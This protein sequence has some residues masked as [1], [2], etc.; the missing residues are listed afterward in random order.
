MCSQLAH[1]FVPDG[2]ELGQANAQ[3]LE[4]HKAIPIQVPQPEQR[5]ELGGVDIGRT[6]R[7]PVT[8]LLWLLVLLLL[9]LLLLRA[10][11][12]CGWRCCCCCCCA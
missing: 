7:A 1:L 5:L 8:L 4:G 3:L 9:L 12:S 11:A 2:L 10:G 6:G